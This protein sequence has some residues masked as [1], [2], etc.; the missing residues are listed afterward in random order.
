M[1]LYIHEFVMI[2]ISLDVTRSSV[3]C[4]IKLL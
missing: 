1:S 3:V 2:I 4:I